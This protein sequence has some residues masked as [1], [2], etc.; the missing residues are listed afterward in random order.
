VSRS[1]P[2]EVF[3]RL[4]DPG[5]AH[6]IDELTG[7]LRLLR[8]WAGN[9]PYE[10]IKDRVNAA[11]ALA[12]RPV[13]E[14]TKRATVVDC[15]KAG[16]RRLNTDLVIAVVA[17]LHPDAGY[18]AQW[19]QAL[20]VVGG[21][22]HAAVQVRAHAS[23]PEDL[24]EFT[25]RGSELEQLRRLVRRRTAT[26][27]AA[28]ISAIEGMAGVG[29]TRLAIHAGHML[30]RE[31]PFD[32][33]LFVNLR[34][35]HP[36]P[37]QPPA[38]PAAVL[39]SFLR[40][41][42][43]P[44][45]KI[46]HDLPGRA[47]AYRERLAGKRALVVLDNAAESDQVRP[48]LPATP[49]CL[50][51]VTS[52]RRLT[53]L[54]QARHLAVDPFTRDEAVEFLKRAAPDVPVGDD[55]HA[56]ARISQRC[57]YL[58]LALALVAGHLRAKPD[59]TLTDHAARLDERH[60]DRRLDSAVEVAL[61][62]SYRHLPAERQR[63]LRLLAMHP[64]HDVDVY[65]AV[66]LTEAGLDTVREHLERMLAEHL[67]QASTPGRYAL[68]D[69]VRDYAAC[70]ASDEDRPP[71]RRA[72]LTRLFDHYLHT[73]AAAMDALHPTDRGRRPRI[74]MPATP[75]PPVADSAEAHAWL[76]KERTNLV[77]AAVHAAT[78]G[79]AE[80]ISGLTNTLSR[81]LDT[82]AHHGDALTLYTHAHGAARRSGDRAAEALA[83]AKLGTV[84]WRLGHYS[85]ATS[86]LQQALTLLREI[87]DLPSQARV[88]GDLGI[89]C[90][91]RGRYLDAAEQHQRA[92]T[93]SREIGD[94]AGQARALG[95]L[96]I[97]YLR[98]GRYAQ[99][100]T[101]HQQAGA[102][103]RQIGDRHGEVY[104]LDNLGKVDQRL[105]RH[106]QAAEHHQQ[107]LTL[108]REIGNRQA[109]VSIL[110]SL[111]NAHRRLGRYPQAIEHLRQALVLSRETGDCQVEAQALTG[112]GNVYQRLGRYSQATEHHQQAL[113]LSRKIGYHSG[114]TE[115]LNNLGRTL[116]AA[117]ESNQARVQHSHALTLATTTG[118]RYEEARALDGLANVSNGTGDTDQARRHWQQALAIYAELDVPDADH[119]RSHLS[120]IDKPST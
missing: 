9:P 77:A 69:L 91:L 106:L 14:W 107:A 37:A 59:W 109:E 42:G 25:G 33:V 119:L 1:K 65:A 68:H 34:G 111:G 47:A 82:G 35:F 31:E 105:G 72:A 108:S 21:H 43:V 87:G 104:A 60:H 39:D 63:L 110:A 53:G 103:S 28:V 113:T 102:L 11:W 18:V 92:L 83:L 45:Q 38:D 98:L 117:G 78:H 57:G 84:H 12:G 94:P 49:G 70:R 41:L 62:L 89:V 120:A 10:V 13:G 95:N 51:L 115:A 100:A 116:L 81:Y 64:G 8:I 2:A 7:R 26:S 6:S 80:H 29:K 71:A 24:V 118:D 23:L 88:V 19:R 50:V 79:W 85:Q 73:A 48:L 76:D 46:P 36:D 93:L 3:A 15:F 30:A 96:G 40:L 97:V 58:P 99:A 17:A 56:P 5:G 27:H 32:R 66:A 114:E 61:S 55:P 16:R 90:Y 86:H 74:P 67:L 75:T 112:L 54:E 52:R 101:H 4:P 44:G 20:R 22:A